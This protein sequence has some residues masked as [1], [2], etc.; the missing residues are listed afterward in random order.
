MKCL[1][2]IISG[3]VQGV[4][5]RQN[6]KNKALELGL[7]GYA[8]NLEDGTVEV[9]AQGDEIKLKEMVEFIRKGPGIS[10]VNDIKMRSKELENFN[11][12]EII[13]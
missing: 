2:I 12:F 7:K 8:R 13:H 9:V 1:H 4:F 6:A 3:R 10:K 11:N 5:F